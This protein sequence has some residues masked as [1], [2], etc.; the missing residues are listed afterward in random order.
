MTQPALFVSHGSPMIVLDP[1][2]ARTFLE[3]YGREHAKPRAIVVASAH[4]EAP[5]PSLSS[6]PAPRTVHDFGG[7]PDALYRIAYPAPGAPDIAA[8]AGDLLRGAGF[9]VRLDPARGFDHGVWTPLKL[10]YPDADVPV[11]DLSVDIART[12][13]WHWRVGQALAPLRDQD[14]MIVGSGS[15]T[16]NLRE[17]F[18][19]HE[20]GTPA[21]VVAFEE[22]L[23]HAIEDGRVDDLLHYRERAPEAVRNHPTE[24]HIL[25]LFVALGAAG[26]APGKRLHH[27]Y[28]RVLAMDTFAFAA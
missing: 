11:V 22:W 7:F 21:W 10:M 1:S 17:Y 23:F 18:R 4:Y 27:S 5:G 25:P 14:V 12:P 2:P 8:R 19:P 16:H 20:P 9:D 24:E 6:G 28:D 15:A 26:A 13:E 3:T